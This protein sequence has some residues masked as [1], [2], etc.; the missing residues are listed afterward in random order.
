MVEPGNTEQLT[1][2]IRE[3]VEDEPR[4]CAFREN[5]RRA[6]PEL[7]WEAQE[8]DLVRLYEGLLRGSRLHLNENA[9]KE[10]TFTRL[11]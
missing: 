8:D 9:Y 11:Q 4:R 10:S 2:A 7:T 5:A 6:A 1:N 3:L